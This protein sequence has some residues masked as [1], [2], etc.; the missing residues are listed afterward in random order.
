MALGYQWVVGYGKRVRFWEGLWFGNSSLAVQ[1][2]Q[3]YVINNEQGAT[4]SQVW[5]SV[6]LKQTFRRAV[7]Q[8]LMLQ[9]DE[10]NQIVSNITLNAEEDGG[11]YPHPCCVAVKYPS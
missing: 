1:F 5:D 3:L 6:E 10:L 4:I 7:S 2:W 9:W 8:R 11:S